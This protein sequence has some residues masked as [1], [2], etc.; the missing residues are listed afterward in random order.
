MKRFANLFLIVSGISL[1]MFWVTWELLMAALPPINL[2]QLFG[3]APTPPPSFW[4][5]LLLSAFAILSAPT[6]LMY[7][8]VGHD[9]SKVLF[10]LLSVVNSI[11]WGLCFSFPI[12]VVKRR[13]F[14]HAA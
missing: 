8:L 2:W 9:S 4:Q 7:E 3:F 13:F 12:Y 14:A 11:A 5:N 6:S 10:V 1:F